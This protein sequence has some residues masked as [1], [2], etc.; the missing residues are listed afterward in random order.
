M[1]STQKVTI[2]AKRNT[3]LQSKRQKVNDDSDSSSLYLEAPAYDSKPV[4]TLKKE[5]NNLS[6]EL[7]ALKNQYDA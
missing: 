4:C 6:Q 5:N 7:A 3:K 1:N 2:S